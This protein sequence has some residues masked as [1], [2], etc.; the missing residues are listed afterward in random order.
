MKKALQFLT[1]IICLWFNVLN[2]LAFGDTK[3]IYPSQDGCVWSNPTP[4]GGDGSGSSFAVGNNSTTGIERSY[5][6]FSLSSI[7]SG[8]TITNATLYCYHIS[9]GGSQTLTVYAFR[10]DQTWSESTLTWP[11]GGWNGYYD[12]ESVSPSTN[13][14]YSWDVTSLV[15]SWFNGTY[16]NYGIA[17]MLYP[18]TEGSISDFAFFR[19]RE[20]TSSSYR[21]YLYVQY[22][23]PNQPPTF[24]LTGPS[25]NII[26]SQ[27]DTVTITWTDSDPDDN[28]SIALAYDTDCSEPGQTWIT[29]NL[30]EDP[31]GS[32]DQYLWDTTGVPTGTYRIWGFIYD[33]HNPQVFSCAPGSV[34]INP[35]SPKPD[36]V[37]YKLWD[38]III[39]SPIAGT[40]ADGTIY[41]GQT[42]YIDYWIANL[43]TD[44]DADSFYV[45]I[46]DDTT[47]ER[48]WREYESSLPANTAFGRSDHEWTF[49]QNGLHVIRIKVDADNN[50]DEGSNENNN[51]YT[52]YVYVYMTPAQPQILSVTYP[53]SITEG[54]W[55]DIDI[56][57][58][59]TGGSSPEGGISLSIPS[60]TDLTDDQL[61]YDDGSSSGTSEYYTDPEKVLGSTIH[62]RNGNPITASYLLAEYV[63][64][65]WQSDEINYLRVKVKPKST[66]TFTFYV[67]S[68]MQTTGGDW[69]NTPLSSSINDQ[70]NWPVNVYSISI[71]TP[72][73]TT[74]NSNPSGARIYLDDVKIGSTP[75]SNSTTL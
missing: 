73:A 60:F 16:N 67:R 21:P 51:E 11:G 18:G 38:D 20:Y 61:I 1:L 41:Q 55:A 6:K 43:S 3:T 68:A 26:V 64:N 5:I 44:A 48:I 71:N 56:A 37:P 74:I 13:A 7:P 52:R 10:A 75:Y 69:I 22:T 9:I 29:A 25:S 46:W 24:N 50:I 33:T 39:I 57:V 63:D 17:L 42:A 15:Q 2:G 32:G 12:S 31:D 36:L 8:S 34:T 45:E 27:G 23:P 66:G 14:W 54:E 59:N 62:D 35:P 70:Q 58:K 53:T 49:I 47:N 4:G 30:N 65:E 19:S 40:S 72:P 28:A